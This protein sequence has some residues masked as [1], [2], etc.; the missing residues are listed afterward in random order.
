MKPVKFALITFFIAVSFTSCQKINGKGEVVRISRSVTGY[1]GIKL[2]MDA[3]VYY[4]QGNI[5]YY[6]TPVIDA[7][8][9]GS[10]N[11]QRL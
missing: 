5:Y 10:G 9:T 1:S 2:S 7:H 6:G 3:T 11:I 8:I 4:T